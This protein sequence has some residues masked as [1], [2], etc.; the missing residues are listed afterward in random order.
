M[1]DLQDRQLLPRW[2]ERTLAASHPARMPNPDR[3]LAEGEPLYTSMVDVFGDDVSGNRSKSWNKHY[4]IYLKH[5]NL[6]REVMQQD[7]QTHFI[8]TSPNASIPE[9][10]QGVKAIIE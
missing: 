7:S 1:L 3:A 6:P 9:Q 2:S 8:S 5:R 4:N 10:F